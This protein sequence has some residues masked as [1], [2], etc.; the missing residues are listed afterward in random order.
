[1]KKNRLH[2]NQKTRM[3]FFQLMMNTQNSKGKESQKALSDL[4]MAAQAIIFIFAGYEST[5]TSICL[6]LYELATHPDVQKKLHDE[7]DSAL[8]N[9]APVT[10]DVL[11]GMEYLDMVINE[12]LRLYPIA[13]RLERIS[14]KAVEINGLFIPKGIT[15]MV[16]TYPLHR[17]PEYWPEPEE[18]RPERFSKEN[19][20]SIDPYVYMPFGN[21]PRN[22]IGMRFALLSM[23]LAVVSVLQNFTLQTC[24][25][26]EN[27][28]KFARQII[29]QPENPI[30]LKI[31]SRD[32]PITGA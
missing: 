29:L 5:S 1:M 25:Q 12:G 24:E 18:F 9:K 15:V 17:D 20:G 10:Y 28:L 23:K 27:H 11:M 13:N 14:K 8:P 7:I 26:T 19:K 16:P 6:V 4:E 22:C 2:S 21:G 31:I 32:K 30:I 3:D